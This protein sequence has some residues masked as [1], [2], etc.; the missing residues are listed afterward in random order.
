MTELNETGRQLLASL[1][2][3]NLTGADDLYW[4]CE[5]CGATPG[6]PCRAKVGTGN[7]VPSHKSRR[8]Q[9]GRWQ[10]WHIDYPGGA[11]AF[12]AVAEAEDLAYEVAGAA[13][14]EAAGEQGHFVP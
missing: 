6:V 2:R 3:E 7:P 12:N 13:D 11:E 9:C 1:A 10:R 8:E 4:S 5:Y 14:R